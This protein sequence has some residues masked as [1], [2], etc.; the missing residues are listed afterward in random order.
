MKDLKSPP[1]EDSSMKDMGRRRLPSYHR[2]RKHGI[3][4][5]KVE[6]EWI[7]T[8]GIREAAIK[9]KTKC[10]ETGEKHLETGLHS[11]QLIQ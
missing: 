3:P 6:T 5:S 1:H 9:F 2:Q 7:I 10:G 8:T 4:L 11:S